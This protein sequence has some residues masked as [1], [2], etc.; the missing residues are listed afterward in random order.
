LKPVKSPL[1]KD[2][3]NL[4]ITPVKPSQNATAS[5]PKVQT[6]PISVSV[7]KLSNKNVMGG[8]VGRGVAPPAPRSTPVVPGGAQKMVSLQSGLTISPR[9]QEPPQRKP[10]QSVSIIQKAGPSV[11]VPPHLPI[12]P[13]LSKQ[14]SVIHPPISQKPLEPLHIS[15]PKQTELSL[16]HKL[17]S[18]KKMAS[19]QSS[20]PKNKSPGDPERGR[21]Q[22]SSLSVSD[23][24]RSITEN[25]FSGASTGDMSISKIPPKQSSILPPGPKL[26]PQRYQPRSELF[27]SI[28]ITPAVSRTDTF[29]GVRPLSQSRVPSQPVDNKYKFLTTVPNLDSSVAET[30]KNFGSSITITPSTIGKSS[31]KPLPNITVQPVKQKEKMDCEVIVLDD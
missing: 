6:S 19:L 8:T 28:S 29:R 22:K 24:T 16:Q 26:N 10:H 20:A 25:K 13:D 14:P 5:H 30:I 31:P 7:Q 15:P 21:V 12:F 3:P 9:G 4:S 17:L 23:I 18:A 2:R 11:P 27:E 1:I